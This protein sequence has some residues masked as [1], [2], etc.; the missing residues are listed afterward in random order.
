VALLPELGRE[1]AGVL[2]AVSKALLSDPAWAPVGPAR[3]V[4][5]AAGAGW[6]WGCLSLDIILSLRLLEAREMLPRFV[7]DLTA[8]LF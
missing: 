3:Q 8:S 1:A 6:S 4:G 5:G 7:Q 2:T